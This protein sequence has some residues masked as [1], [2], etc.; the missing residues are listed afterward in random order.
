MSEIK[1]ISVHELK[2]LKDAGEDYLL[3]DVRNIDEYKFCNFDDSKL[4][5][6][7]EM[8]DRFGEIPKE[9]R[10]IVHCHHGGRSKKVIQW[11]QDHHGYTNLINLSGGIHAWSTEIDTGVPIY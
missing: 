9:G 6:M 10:V 2:Q 1:E 7:P 5:P 3:I 8:M 4:L 11:L